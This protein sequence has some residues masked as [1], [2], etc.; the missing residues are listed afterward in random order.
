MI[1]NVGIPITITTPA[2]VIGGISGGYESSK[3]LSNAT[4]S[5]HNRF[6][7]DGVNWNMISLAG[8]THYGDL[9][10]PARVTASEFFIDGDNITSLFAPKISPS[11]TGLLSASGGVIGSNLILNTTTTLTSAVYGGRVQVANG[12]W[13]LT[14]PPVAAGAFFILHLHGSVTGDMTI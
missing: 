4:T 9:G 3:V 2:G 1:L 5:Q 11:F 8:L 10:V 13:T 7:S 12:G 14:F 6:S